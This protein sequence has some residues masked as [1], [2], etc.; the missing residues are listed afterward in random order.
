M[1]EY[2]TDLNKKSSVGKL[3]LLKKLI[4]SLQVEKGFIVFL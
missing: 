1:T 3:K 2:P 4:K